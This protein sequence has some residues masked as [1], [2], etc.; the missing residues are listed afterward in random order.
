MK[1]EQIDWVKELE[2][3]EE[4]V[5]WLETDKGEGAFHSGDRPYTHSPYQWW[6]KVPIDTSKIDEIKERQNNIVFKGLMKKL[7]R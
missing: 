2:E 7:N 5:E 6:K 1:L 3:D 4:L